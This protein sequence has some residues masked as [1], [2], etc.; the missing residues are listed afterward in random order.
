[1]FYHKKECLNYI[2][3]LSFDKITFMDY[4]MARKQ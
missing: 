3:N 1:M 4:N 2:G